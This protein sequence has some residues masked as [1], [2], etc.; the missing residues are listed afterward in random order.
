MSRDVVPGLR[1]AR[2]HET[3]EEGEEHVEGVGDLSW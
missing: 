3:G 1:V 2:G